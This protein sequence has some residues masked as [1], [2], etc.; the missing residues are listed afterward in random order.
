M[1][2]TNIEELV[3]SVVKV[4]GVC[5]TLFN[6][7]RQLFGVRLLVPRGTD[8]VIQKPASANP[9]AIPVQ[10]ISSLLQF[11]AQG[12]SGHRVKVAGTVV[13]QEPGV[14]LFIQDEQG[15]LYCQTRQRV[16]VNLTLEAPP[17][18]AGAEAA[19][20]SGFRGS[21]QLRISLRRGHARRDAM[22]PGDLERCRSPGGYGQ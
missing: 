2:V 11:T 1:P 19:N 4:R 12:T 10:S 8:L 13:Y 14:A 20:A 6:R 22:R 16:P 15:G 5:S 9:F 7:L 18:D 21:A 3:E 17:G